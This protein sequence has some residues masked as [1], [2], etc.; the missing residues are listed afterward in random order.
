[1][2]SWRRERTK[3]KCMPFS[4]ETDFPLF[5]AGSMR[6][7][8]AGFEKTE[9]NCDS[10]FRFFYSC[11]VFNFFLDPEGCFPYKHSCSRGQRRTVSSVGRAP[12]SHGG[13]HRFKSCTV[14]HYGAVVKTVIT[15][16]CHAGGRGFESLPL[17]HNHA[18]APCTCRALFL[19]PPLRAARLVLLSRP[20]CM[21]RS[22]T[23]GL[24]FAIPVTKRR[25]YASHCPYHCKIWCHYRHGRP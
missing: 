4:T 2:K 21:D 16:A 1:M 25:A 23:L 5:E 9:Q 10:L 15:P 8:G 22:K 17:R 19:F 24:P 13:G 12:P 6:N 11:K 14:H 3:R 7:A 20:S 18:K